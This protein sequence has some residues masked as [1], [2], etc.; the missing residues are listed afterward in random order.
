MCTLALDIARPRWPPLSTN[1]FFD[2]SPGRLRGTLE[3]L[4]A[5]NHKHSGLAREA[6]AARDRDERGR[7]R[8]A[9]PRGDF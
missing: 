8:A 4:A 5:H 7:A 3:R 9:R 1:S 6:G 2:G